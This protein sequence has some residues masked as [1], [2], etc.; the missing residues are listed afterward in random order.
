MRRKT[1]FFWEVLFD[2]L[3]LALGMVLKFYTSVAKRLKLKVKK[4]LGL[5]PTFV[6]VTGKKLFGSIFRL[7]HHKWV[8]GFF[9]SFKFHNI[10]ARL[11]ELKYLDLLTCWNCH[12][13]WRVFN[14]PS[15][16]LYVINSHRKH[17]KKICSENK[18]SET[19]K[20][21]EK[22]QTTFTMIWSYTCVI[23]HVTY[24]Y[25]RLVRRKASVWGYF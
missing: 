5:I 13:F 4:F 25:L 12:V 14:I 17:P 15:N 2:N 1:L 21:L 11:D 7:P 19:Y 16:W 24:T 8:Y 3:E 18:I 9:L 10:G 20:L 23:L 22:H 6:E